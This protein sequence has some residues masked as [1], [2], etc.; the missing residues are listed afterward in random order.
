MDCKEMLM[1]AKQSLSKKE[2]ESLQFLMNKAVTRYEYM[3]LCE[4]IEKRKV[5]IPTKLNDKKLLLEVR[6]LKYKF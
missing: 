3:A 1:Q 2:Y 4:D 5:A 6:I